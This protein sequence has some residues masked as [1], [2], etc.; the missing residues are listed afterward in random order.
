MAR[1]AF[2]LSEDLLTLD[3]PVLVW[4]LLEIMHHMLILYHARLFQ[5]LLVHLI[6]LVDGRMPNNHPLSTMLHS[7]RG[8]VGSLRSGRPSPKEYPPSPSSSFIQLHFISNDK[9]T[10]KSWLRYLSQTLSPLLERAWILNAEIIFDNFDPRLFHLY[11]SIHWDSCSV[12]PPAAMLGAAHHWINQIRTQQDDSAT[13]EARHAAELLESTPVEEQRMLQ[14]LLAPRMDASPP[15]DFEMLRTGS[16]ATLRELGNS[17]FSKRAGFV[18]STNTMLRIFVG[19]LKAEVFETRPAAVEDSKCA[20]I[21]KVK[22]PRIHADHLAGRMMT[23]MELTA[24]QGGDTAGPPL[25]TVDWIRSVVS[26]REYARSEIDPQVVREM[27]LLQD[28][29][30]TADRHEEA[31]EVAESASRRVERYIQDIPVDSVYRRIDQ[32]Q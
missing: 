3:G 18:G 23:L 13:S 15:R 2:L 14:R 27:W 4:N 31:G 22:A 19:V 5:M 9:L 32:I 7:L 29:L 12:S 6:A 25:D 8:L 16:I 10:T 20:G 26:L 1:K 17:V 30:I 24:E 11:S 21:V 28:A